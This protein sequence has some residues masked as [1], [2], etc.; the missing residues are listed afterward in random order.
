MTTR[1][2]EPSATVKDAEILV[3]D[4]HPETLEVIGRNLMA[5]G[6]RVQ[7]VSSVGAAVDI[8]D[9]QA[10]D[11]VKLLQSHD[12]DDNHADVISWTALVQFHGARQ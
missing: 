2:P 3:V 7:T 12:R 11:L 1:P 4:D 6:H 5:A 8:L 9:R 10:P